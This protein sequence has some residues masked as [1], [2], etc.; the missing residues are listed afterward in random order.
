MDGSEFRITA[1]IW[2]HT[3]TW[4]YRHN[5]I[6]AQNAHPEDGLNFDPRE[7]GDGERCP[8]VIISIRLVITDLHINPRD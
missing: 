2:Q 5:Q 1:A 8:S 4:D 7:T 6:S 3:D